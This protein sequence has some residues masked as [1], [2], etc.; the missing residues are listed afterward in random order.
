MWFSI[1]CFASWDYIRVRWTFFKQERNC[2]ELIILL[3]LLF[4]IHC[5][6]CC[7]D[8]QLTC[9]QLV[10]WAVFVCFHKYSP[11]RSK[12][13]ICVNRK[14]AHLFIVPASFW[15]LWL[16]I[17]LKTYVYMCVCVSRREE[18]REGESHVTLSNYN[19]CLY[20]Y[21]MYFV[22]K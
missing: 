4:L 16:E 11:E 20:Y 15:L 9:T 6:T 2:L 5:D 19:A 1:V 8:D 18:E 7:I 10:L 3:S 17:M 22:I 14:R 13:I 12:V 21:G